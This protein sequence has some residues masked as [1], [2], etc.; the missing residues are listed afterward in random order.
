VQLDPLAVDGDEVAGLLARL[1]TPDDDAGQLV[2]PAVG[3]GSSET[4]LSVYNCVLVRICVAQWADNEGSAVS[5]VEVVLD[6]IDVLG[7]GV[8]LNR[9]LVFGRDVQLR[10]LDPPQFGFLAEAV[11]LFRLRHPGLVC[12]PEGIARACEENSANP[13]HD[14]PIS[15]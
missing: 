1:P 7:R 8:G 13:V 11:F 2:D 4:V 9:A 5:P 10:Q 14:Q 6:V 3:L 15:A 12:S